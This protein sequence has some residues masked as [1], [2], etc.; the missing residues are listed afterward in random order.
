MSTSLSVYP[1]P[2]TS[3][4]VVNSVFLND[5]IAFKKQTFSLDK[6]SIASYERDKQQQVSASEHRE[7]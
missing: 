7:Q 5:G 4:N 2:Q 6:R 1:T 3:H